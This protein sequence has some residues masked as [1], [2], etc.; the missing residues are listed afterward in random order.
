MAT[1]ERAAPRGFTGSTADVFSIPIS[2][3]FVPARLVHVP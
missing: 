1:A 2:R 3:L